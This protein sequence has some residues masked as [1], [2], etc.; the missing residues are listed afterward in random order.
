[1]VDDAI[2]RYGER[3]DPGYLMFPE[4]DLHRMWLRGLFDVYNDPARMAR[5][6]E[7]VG[8]TFFRQM[9]RKFYREHGVLGEALAARFD[10]SRSEGLDYAA[11]AAE[12][13]E[14]FTLPPLGELVSA[15]SVAGGGN[16]T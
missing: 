13:E 15:A 5:I 8:A 11:A 3:A 9:Y 16:G 12:A 7:V 1:M 14:A 10:R 2:E 4:A 6:Q